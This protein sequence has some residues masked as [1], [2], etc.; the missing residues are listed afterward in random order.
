MQQFL[1]KFRNHTVKKCGV[2]GKAGLLFC[3]GMTHNAHRACSNCPI[4]MAKVALFSLSGG[5][6]EPR[7]LSRG[8]LCKV[9][10]GLAS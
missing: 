3:W 10:M 1:Q 6:W 5:P 4:A 8:S 7:A 2:T 9:M